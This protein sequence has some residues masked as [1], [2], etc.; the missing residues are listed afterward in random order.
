VTA[1]LIDAVGGAILWSEKIDG[2]AR[3]VL[4]I[5]DESRSAS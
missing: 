3:D 2:D 5:Q 4:A 1:Q